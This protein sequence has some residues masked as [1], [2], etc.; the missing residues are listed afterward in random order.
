M[1]TSNP[2]HAGE[3]G[4]RSLAKSGTL[5]QPGP[6]LGRSATVGAVSAPDS[7]SLTVPEK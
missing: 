1:L 5:H 3:R 7:Q 4:R 2:I 6:M